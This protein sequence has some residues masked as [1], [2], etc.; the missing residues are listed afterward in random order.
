ME[1]LIGS[2]KLEL[3]LPEILMAETEHNII[4]YINLMKGRY[5]C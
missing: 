2:K 4:E 3:E 5:V 1:L